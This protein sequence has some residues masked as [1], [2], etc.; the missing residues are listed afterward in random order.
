MCMI[1]RSRLYSYKCS[2][3]LSGVCY[4]VVLSLYSLSFLLTFCFLL[5]HFL[6]HTWGAARLPVL[7]VY[8][9]RQIFCL[10]FFKFSYHRSAWDSPGQ[11]R[12]YIRTRRYCLLRPLCS[13]DVSSGAKP[14][15]AYIL[16]DIKKTCGPTLQRD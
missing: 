14:G 7:N 9:G 16:E 4:R 13:D 6:W 3:L 10:F 2:L 15:S 12:S 5:L 11:I 1:A 8:N